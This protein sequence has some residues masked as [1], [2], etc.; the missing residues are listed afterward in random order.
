MTAPFPKAINQYFSFLFDWGFSIKE[1]EDE[2]TNLFGNG[3]YIFVSNRV[4]IEIVLDRGDVLM[5]IGKIGQA[6]TDWL[7]WSI[8]LAAFDTQTNAY[9]F[10]LSVEAQVKHLGELL[11]LHGFEILRGDFSNPNLHKQIVE[12]LGH[13]FLDRFLRY[14]PETPS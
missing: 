8:I 5:S 7:D 9:E 4:G 2:N 13:A 10:E 14:H 12:N 11:H 3:Y 1:K 6:R